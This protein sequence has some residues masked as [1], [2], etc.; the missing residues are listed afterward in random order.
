MPMF[1]KKPVVIEARQ[2]LW[3]DIPL[4]DLPLS[5]KALCEWCGGELA[6]DAF[7]PCI[8]IDTPEGQMRANP[9]DWIIKGVKGEFYPCKPEIFAVTYDV[10]EA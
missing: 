5:A 10:V 1:R 7:G 8:L 6:F 3:D 4:G 2:F 9:A